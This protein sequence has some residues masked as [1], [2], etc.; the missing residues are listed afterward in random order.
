MHGD[1]VGGVQHARRRAARQR[2]LARQAQARERVEVDRLERQLADRGQVQ[3]RD[4]QLHALA[5]VQRVGDRDAHVRAGRGG[6]ASRRRRAGPG[7]GRATAGAR[8]TSIRSYGVP[9]R[10][11]ASIS[12]RPLFISVAESIVILPPI[13]QVGCAS[14]CSTVTSCS[15]ARVRPRNGP[16]L[17][18]IVRRSTAPGGWPASSWCSAVCSE[19]T[20]T[21][22]APVASAS[23]LTSSP[24]TTSDSLLASARSMPSPSVATVGPRP[25]R[26]DERV[27][28]EI[29]AGLDDEPHEPLGAAE[30][31]PVGPR[32][33]G[34][35]R[36]VARRRARSAARRARGP[37]RRAPPTSARRTARRA[38]APRCARSTSSA[39]VP[40]EPVEPRISRRLASTGQTRLT[41]VHTRTRCSSRRRPRTAPRRAGRARRRARRTAAGVLDVEPRA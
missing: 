14:A 40:I 10:W 30:H 38:R 35:R 23:A 4:R 18:V 39:C 16:P 34:A 26:A 36:G 28:H 21:I 22:C 9:N 15:C 27:Q 19:S 13:A 24:P 5:A 7:R 20:G 2:R 6:R 41:S 25:G 11:W 1:L 29:G 12:S 37:A 32:L 3:R 17:A 8:R 33:R 31:L